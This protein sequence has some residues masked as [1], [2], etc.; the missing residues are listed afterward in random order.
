MKELIE[1][2]NIN[3]IENIKSENNKDNAKKS[4]LG[5]TKIKDIVIGILLVIWMIIPLLKEIQAT[6]IF[7]QKYEYSIMEIIAIAG[8][9]IFTYEIY[10]RIKN[11]ENKKELIKELLPI[12]LLTAYLIW[13]LISCIFAQDKQKAFYGTDYRKD[14]FITYLVYAGFFLS[15][16]LIKSNKIKKILLNVFLIVSLLNI[17]I[18]N[19]TSNNVS[20]LKMF[21][22]RKVEIGVFLNS[23]HYGYYLLLATIIACI[24]LITEKNKILKILY[25]GSYIILLYNLIYNNTLGCYIALTIVLIL[26]LIYSIYSKKYIKISGI[27][28]LIFITLSCVVQK[29]DKNIVISNINSMIKDAKSIINIDTNNNKKDIE[30]NNNTQNNKK[31]S[32]NS[33]T[34]NKISDKELRKIG[35]GRG[36]LWKYG[37]IMILEKPLLGYGA[38]NLE[39]EYA[40]YN[41]D[42]D[43]PHNL[44]IQL[45]TTSGIPGL[46]LYMSAIVLILIRGIKKLKEHNSEDNSIYLVAYFAVIAY[47]ISAMFGN[48]MYYTSPYFFILLGIVTRSLLSRC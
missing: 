11:A 1:K 3:K 37:T 42:Q 18:I 44:L 8:I 12:I 16:Y 10:R 34:N 48:S 13:T 41:I 32:S 45:A 2:N 40:K 5:Y 6:T 23:N 31:D 22:Y 43:R 36:E 39:E 28:L 14:G 15:A 25:L 38:E 19:L 9:Y 7:I 33:N 24:L 35:S 26:F 20:L 21:I 46:L 47:L 30:E 27:V 17:L 29:N 4:K